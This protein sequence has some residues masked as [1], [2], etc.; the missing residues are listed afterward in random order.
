MAVCAHMS[1]GVSDVQIVEFGVWVPLSDSS[2]FIIVADVEKGEIEGY[3]CSIAFV[4]AGVGCPA[5][6]GEV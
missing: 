4:G 2:G 1:E 5:L 6:D 3:S